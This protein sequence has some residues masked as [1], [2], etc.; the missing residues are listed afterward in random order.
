MAPSRS[1][2]LL[3]LFCYHSPYVLNVCA[4]D[5]PLTHQQLHLDIDT[6]PAL[7]SE[8]HG[9]LTLEPKNLPAILYGLERLQLVFRVDFAKGD[10]AVGT[11]IA[12][13]IKAHLRTH[14]LAFAPPSAIASDAFKEA[15]FP[16]TED[17]VLVKCRKKIGKEQYNPAVAEL[18]IND[19][20][21]TSVLQRALTFGTTSYLFFGTCFAVSF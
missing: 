20:K 5:N 7:H 2:P 1:K 13:T 19:F 6:C 10:T 18:P 14:R 9:P 21:F 15:V 4:I 11:E 16:Y 8:A 12:H 3:R 17:W